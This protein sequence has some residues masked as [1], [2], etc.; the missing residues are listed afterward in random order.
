MTG[1]VSEGMIGIPSRSRLVP[2]HDRTDGLV[3]IIQKGHDCAMVLG[4]VLAHLRLHYAAQG[5]VLAPVQTSAVFLIKN[6][7]III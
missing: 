7:T 3:G 2:V 4:E 6:Q 5:K 1:G